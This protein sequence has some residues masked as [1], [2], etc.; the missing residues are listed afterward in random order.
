MNVMRYWFSKFAV[1]AAFAIL[2]GVLSASVAAQT[3]V[4]K[5]VATV[6][7]GLRVELITLSD[8]KWQLALQPGKPVDPPTQ[9]DLEEVLQRVIDQRIFLL[10]A[11]RL[12]R[13]APT[14][15][16]IAAE[17][18]K[19]LTYFPSTAEFER[20]LRAVGFSSI[21][22]DNFERIVAQRLAIEKYLDFRFRSFVVITRT[23]ES[24]Y[25][26]NYYVPEFRRNNPGRVVPE[27]DAARNEINER[28]REERVA[29]NI[30]TFVDDARR[31]VEIV[32]LSD[33]GN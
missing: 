5:T 15:A 27:L 17:I 30:E 19:L 14:E 6:S 20:R 24:E 33:I 10:E 3:V 28:L 1:S 21:S 11:E 4:D 25:Y 18:A 32:T 22:D 8:L 9:S 7:D 13:N 29:E 26:E 31:R 16:E 2:A 12:P 23:D